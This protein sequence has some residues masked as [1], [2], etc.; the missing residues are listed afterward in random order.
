MIEQVQFVSEL[1]DLI[2]SVRPGHYEPLPNGSVRIVP[3]KEMQFINGQLSVDADDAE[4]LDALRRSRLYGGRIH[5]VGGQVAVATAPPKV[6]T[7]ELSALKARLAQ[8]EA[9]LMAKV[10]APAEPPLNKFRAA[11]A[12]A[13]LLGIKGERDWKTEDYERAI[14]Q[15]GAQ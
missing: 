1:P 9:L 4:S 12:K 10:E 7:D 5:E 3:G 6:D 14:E 15:A 2:V 11:K 8:L 13:E